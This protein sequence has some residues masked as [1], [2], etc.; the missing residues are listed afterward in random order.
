[1]T[2]RKTARPNSD[3]PADLATLGL[4]GLNAGLDDLVARATRDRW[5]PRQV[6]EEAARIEVAD[7][8]QRSLERRT[9][10]ARNGAFKTIGDFDWQWPT[11][12]D[13]LA[14]ERIL[15]LE[16]M[17][18]PA[19][20]ILIGPHGVG[21]TML[22]KN[23]ANAAIIAGYTVQ[24]VTVAQM[25]LDLGSQDSPR[26]LDRRLKHYARPHLLVLDEVGYLAYD[27]HAAD[28][29]YQVVALR[30]EKKPIVMTTNL[31]FAQWPQTFPNAN[32]V[33][34]L[35]DRLTH[36]AEIVAIEGKSF[37][38]REAEARRKPADSERRNS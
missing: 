35:V 22:A 27:A 12:I 20:V 16:F 10:R 21:K 8:A 9:T 33:A 3:L 1:M 7:R 19:N 17:R 25:L 28:L 29:L 14:I 30:H 11:R 4:K 32:S 31:A 37:R 6:L 38:H 18:E 26:I 5:G 2:S 23:I 34:A 24:V 15:S 13:R 36:R